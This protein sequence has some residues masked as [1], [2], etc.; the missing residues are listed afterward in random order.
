[1]RHRC[2]PGLPAPW[3]PDVSEAIDRLRTAPDVQHV[4]VMPDVHLAADVCI[5]VVVATS[6]LIYP[7]AVGS[8]IGC[9][10][11]AVALRHRC[12]PARGP[13]SCGRRPGRHRARGAG[14][15]AKPRVALAQPAEL[16]RLVAQPPSSRS[17][18]AHGTARSSSQRSAAAITSWSCRPTRIGRLWLMLH[19][20]SRGVGQAIRNHHLQ[21][22]EDAGGTLKRSTREPRPA[23]PTSPTPRG[24]DASLTRAGAAI[25]WRS[26]RSLPNRSGR[27]RLLGHSHCGRPQSR[28]A[29][30]HGG[31][32]LVGPS[33][34]SH[35][36]AG[37]GARS[38]S[39]VDG[40]GELPRRR[41]RGRRRAVLERPWRGA[42]H[43]PVG[44]TAEVTVKAI[45]ASR[46]AASGTTIVTPTIC[47]TKPRPRTRTSAPSFGRN[48]TS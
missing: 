12:Q 47:A 21:R 23:R 44:G 24:Q 3:V 10:M 46:C 6:H 37:R 43:E 34:G 35:A 38:P 15:P 39:R 33:Q 13:A 22:A 31:R 1:M 18:S 9:G 16:A 5:G 26:G 25:A 20:G 17:D 4:A 7:Q 19:T 2:G 40:D 41:A 30:E 28:G 45:C 14:R 11:L 8:D 36:G 27:A 42:C 32:E 48:A 29:Q